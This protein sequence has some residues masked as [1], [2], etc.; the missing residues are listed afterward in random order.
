MSEWPELD[1]VVRKKEE[2]ERQREHAAQLE[3][4]H[5]RT[6]KEQEETRRGEKLALVKRIF[7]T[8][9]PI[10]RKYLSRIA[11]VT[12]PNRDWDISN[13]Y[14]SEIYPASR[15]GSFEKYL[16]R[17]SW[18]VGW[19]SY[20]DGTSEKEDFAVTILLNDIQPTKLI[21]SGADSYSAEPNENALKSALVKTFEKGPH[22]DYH[23]K[24]SSDSGGIS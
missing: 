17:I 22:R 15:Y 13:S 2:A 19:S 5:R 11:E 18:K 7:L 9:D 12:W 3:L 14:P 20:S 24:E 10:V 23:Y 4:E 8:W 6:A 16:E 1:D 21:V